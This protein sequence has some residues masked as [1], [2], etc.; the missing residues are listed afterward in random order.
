M[1]LNIAHDCNLRCQYCFASTGDFGEG[2]KL[3][4]Y[5][6]GKKAVDFLLKNSGDR[7]NLEMDFFGGEPLMNFETVKKIVEY[8][9][10]QEP[11]YNKKFRFTITTNGM[12]LTDD[13]IDFI[14]REMSNVVLSID[15]RKDVNDRMRPRV[16]GKG[17][18]DES[19]PCTKSW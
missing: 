4:S 14:N 11:V 2:R 3:M 1:C 17:S 9:R 16:D 8:A 12:L 13:K 7:V 18:Y 15:G 5:E 6:T 10:S 19:S